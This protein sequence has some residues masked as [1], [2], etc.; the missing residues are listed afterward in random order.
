M[1]HK[2]IRYVSTITVYTYGDTP[3]EAFNEAQSICEEINHKYDG[4]AKVEKLHAQ[5]FGTL[6]SKEININNLKS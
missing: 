5:P 1:S 3:E 2:K 4:Q 6:V